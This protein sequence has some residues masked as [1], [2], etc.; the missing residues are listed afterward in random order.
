MTEPFGLTGREAVREDSSGDETELP[1]G[2]VAEFVQLLVKTVRA[3]QIYDTANPVYQRFLATLREHLGGIWSRVEVLHLRVEDHGFEWQQQPIDSGE[4]KENLAFLFYKDGIRSVSFMPGFEDEV[5]RFLDVMHKARHMSRDSEDLITL[6][7]ESD[8][9]GF[10]YDFVDQ[11]AQGLEIPEGGLGLTE[12]LPTEVYQQEIQA[13]EEPGAEEETTAQAG[14]AAP[15]PAPMEGIVRPENF[16]ETLFFLD[17]SELRVLQQ[18]VRREMERDLKTDVLNALFDRLEDADE[19][20]QAEVLDIL[21][22]LLPSLLIRGDMTSASRILVE[23]SD[24]LEKPGLLEGP[25]REHAHALFEELSRPESV[26]QLVRALE[27][28]VLQPDAQELGVFFTHLRPS[29]LPLLMAATRRPEREDV[30]RRIEAGVDAIAGQNPAA[31]L[32]LLEAELPDVAAA[33]AAMAA[34]LR[35]EESAPGLARLME[36]PETDVRLAAIQAAL[37]LHTSATLNIVLMGLEDESREVRMEAARGLAEYRYQPARARLEQVIRERVSKDADRTERVLFYEAY[38]QV[39]GPDAVPYLDSVLNGRRLGMRQATE[40][41][42][43]AARAL[44][45]I[46]APNARAALQQAASDKDV[47]VRNEVSRALRQEASP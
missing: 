28:G 1:H 5:A 27:D 10:R 43:C 22:Q 37:A 2:E 19:E 40:L 36:R 46:P 41:R 44:G 18:E 13:A 45:L 20:R 38:A 30:R 16:Q 23:L 14:A 21:Q 31:A 24:L 7:W 47:V 26:D 39:G 34:R 29:A 32:E 12:G 15:P 11:L 4:G 42:A 8:F 6:L 3:H 25:R 9:D 33:A 17:E 35:L